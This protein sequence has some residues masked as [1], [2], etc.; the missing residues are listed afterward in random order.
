MTPEI[1]R[2][3]GI[4]LILRNMAGE[5]TPAGT[6]I[7]PDPYPAKAQEIWDSYELENWGAPEDDE[8]M[9]EPQ[10]VNTAAKP[11]RT[12]ST[13]GTACYRPAPPDHPIYGTN[14]IMH[15]IR[16]GR[17][18]TTSYKI[19]PALSKVNYNVRGHNG[20]RVGQWWPLQICALRDGAHGKRMA[21][22]AGS[23]LEGVFSVI[24]SGTL[25]STFTIVVTKCQSPS[26]K[27]I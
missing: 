26:A 1:E 3:L 23:Q 13:A 15:D 14:G 16:K 12:S 20:L 18:M 9:V 6:F 4:K 25:K 11:K 2:G 21:G 24:V 5:T 17:K 8:F 7:L 10:S 27:H 22:I 19:N